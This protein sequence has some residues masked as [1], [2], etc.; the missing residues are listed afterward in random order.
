MA[1]S[2]LPTST[3]TLLLPVRAL[4]ET[5]IGTETVLPE[6]VA[7]P[8]VIPG[9]EKYTAKLPHVEQPVPVTLRRKMVCAPR[10]TA[11]GPMIESEVGSGFPVATKDPVAGASPGL[12]TTTV[13]LPV[14]AP[15][16][17]TS[18][19]MV[20]LLTTVTEPLTTLKSALAPVPGNDTV[21]PE[22][23]F[24]PVMVQ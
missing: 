9:L 12:V 8:P 24:V 1:K 5:V 17:L 20:V 4:G 7:L 18:R 14:V 16:S 10:L 3:V 13:A 2:L 15:V 21:A 6:H 22:T 19:T 11:L 23:K